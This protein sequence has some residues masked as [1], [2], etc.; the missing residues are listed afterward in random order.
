M[1]FM[2]G[3]KYLQNFGLT[4]CFRQKTNV[5]KCSSI[6]LQQ[7]PSGGSWHGVC[8]NKLCIPSFCFRTLGEQQAAM[9]SGKS[10]GQPSESG[11]IAITPTYM[12]SPRK[13]KTF[14]CVFSYHFYISICQIIEG[15]FS[16]HMATS[17]YILLSNPAR[18]GPGPRMLLRLCA[19]G[20]KKRLGHSHPSI[21]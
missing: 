7:L 4:L 11:S 9:L 1:L 14:W 12:D 5:W 18:T 20:C 19:Q 6:S 16:K 15:Y 10:S 8:L 17:Y 2:W 21:L 13:V 3:K